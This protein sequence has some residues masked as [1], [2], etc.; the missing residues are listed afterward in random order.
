MK[1]RGKTFEVS[2]MP[3]IAKTLKVLEPTTP[4]FHKLEH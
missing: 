3:F 1:R 4:Q 2:A